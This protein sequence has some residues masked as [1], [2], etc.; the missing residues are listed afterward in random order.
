MKASLEMTKRMNA[1]ITLTTIL[2]IITGFNA[3]SHR[4]EKNPVETVD[5]VEGDLVFRKGFGPKTE[6]VIQADT[7][8]IY[9]HAGIVVRQDSVFRIVHITPGERAKGETVD[10]IKIESPEVFFGSDRAQYGA[11]YRLHDGLSCPAKAAQHAL[12][13]LHKGIIFDHDYRLND[14]T[15]MYCAEFVWYAYQLAGTDISF[16]KRSELENIPLY[17]GVYIFPSDIY[18][19]SEF[20]LIYKF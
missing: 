13:L 19:N 4:K 2:L 10:R 9:S 11:V 5:F 14:T 3:C 8:G 15:K 18:R 16:G 12:R 7:L 20:K 1:S 17:S 6:A